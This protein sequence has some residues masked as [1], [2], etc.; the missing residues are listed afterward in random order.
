MPGSAASSKRPLVV[1]CGAF[2][3][4]VL[5][6]ALIHELAQQFGC[7]V[8][9]VTSG[10]W[11]A[12]L[13]RGQP[14]VGEIL[15]VR[16]RKA[17]YWLSVDQQR[18][19]RRLRARGPGPT[20]YCDGNDAAR[21]LLTRAGVPDRFIVEV[22]DHPLLPGEHATQQWRRLAH[23]MPPALT[24]APESA[25]A[26]AVRAPASGCAPAFASGPAAGLADFA[27]LAAP[28][29]CCLEVSDAQ[30]DDLE[31]WLPTRLPSAPLI[32]IQA[33]NKRTMRRGLRRLAVNH[34][35]W[36]NERWALVLRHLRARHPGHAIVLLGAVPEYGLNE[37][38]AALAGIARLYNVA[39]DLPVTRLIALLARAEGL[40]TVDSGPAHAAAAVGCPQVVLFGN[41]STS[42]YRPWGT[43]GADVKVLTG[44]IDGEP[45]MLG[46]GPG[47]V[48]AAWD[49]LRLRPTRASYPE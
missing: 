20:W 21:P 36:P 5:I 25:S 41:A 14:G 32:A 43:S 12:P 16:S 37:E 40:V 45:S 31:R 47:E 34:K 30:R 33:G 13:L 27:A 8:D 10:P 48:A 4:M 24:T 38:L 6:T 9:V 26:A 23:I 7:E 15:S 3:D 28:G 1:R 39:D 46:I 19:V 18:V 17:P 49:A 42:L 22:K 29:G 35:Y 2:G 44:R 11:S